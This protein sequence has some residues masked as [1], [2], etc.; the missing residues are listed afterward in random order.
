[1]Y[2]FPLL[3]LFGFDPINAFIIS[4]K[5]Q[6]KTS[7]ICKIHNTWVD[8]S[9]FYVHIKM[10]WILHNCV[11]MKMFILTV[12]VS[13]NCFDSQSSRSCCTQLDFFFQLRKTFRSSTE[14]LQQFLVAK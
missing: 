14:E 12:L 8:S 6:V 9:S 1:M 13:K 7:N 10:D 5:C 11:T 2:V 3:V 4:E